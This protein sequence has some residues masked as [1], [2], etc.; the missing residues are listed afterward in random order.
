[1]PAL[2][3]LNE[4]WTLNTNNARPRGLAFGDG[5]YWIP[6][7]KVALIYSY[8]PPF[9]TSATI[10]RAGENLNA[11]GCVFWDDLLFTCD[12]VDRRAYAF[13]TT[14]TRNS[15]REG[16]LYS[17]NTFPNGITHGDG[18][19]WVG[20]ANRGIFKYT[21]SW[22]HVSSFALPGVGIRGLTFGE[23]FLWALTP[24]HVHQITTDG[25][26]VA[27]HDLNPDNNDG[28]A[29]LYHEGKILVVDA[30]DDIVF[31]YKSPIQKTV[32]G[33][34]GLRFV[35]ISPS[36]DKFAVTEYD[37]FVS[38][39]P[40]NGTNEVGI[41]KY[42][43]MWF[44][45]TTGSNITRGIKRYDL[46]FN[47]IGV[48]ELVDLGNPVGMSTFGKYLLVLVGAG[49]SRNELLFLTGVGVLAF[50]V[51]LTSNMDYRALASDD[52]Y[53]YLIE[54]S[55]RKIERY[56][57]TLGTNSATLGTATLW[58]ITDGS[59]RGLSVVGNIIYAANLRQKIRTFNKTDGS[60][61]AIAYTLD[62]QVDTPQGLYAEDIGADPQTLGISTTATVRI[63]KATAKRSATQSLGIKDE[64]TAAR[65]RILTRATVQKLGIK[66]EA[67]AGIIL[68]KPAT[69]NLGIKDEISRAI[70][71]I[72]V[73][74][75]TQ[76]LG[77]KSEVSTPRISVMRSVTQKLGISKEIARA[78]IRVR[79]RA[80]TQKLGIKSTTTATITQKRII[81]VI[82]KLG[83]GTSTDRRFMRLRSA[84]QK[85]GFNSTTSLIFPKSA[86]QN[87]GIKS[88]IATNII[89]G[90]TVSVIQKLGMQSTVDTM[91]IKAA[92]QNVGISKEI[93]RTRI[94]I[95]KR[96]V[97]QNL[98]VKNEAV[99]NLISRIDVI[100]KLGI[101][102]KVDVLDRLV[103]SA[104][105]KL[106]IKGFARERGT[107][108]VSQGLGISPVA[109]K[110]FFHSAEDTLGIKSTATRAKIR[111]LIRSAIQNLG[112]KTTHQ[113]KFFISVRQGLAITKDAATSKIRRLPRSATDT[114]GIKSTVTDHRVAHRSVTQK[115]GIKSVASDTLKAIRHAVQGLIIHGS[116]GPV[117][118]ST[119]PFFRT[120][121]RIR[122]IFRV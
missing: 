67:T 97:S 19:F 99:H 114:I 5:K 37:E 17:L 31:V 38:T 103:R 86:I 64:A 69:Q 77:V 51:A 39:Y 101:E 111:R 90:F 102:S 58:D 56:E 12:Y 95:R 63:I 32:V 57:V 3:R 105:Q 89:R 92:K 91:F 25:T 94:R 87:L 43:D 100:Q 70:K 27:L 36:T 35:T 82:Q 88:G 4:G 98:G 78:R 54:I 109:T 15:G 50:K 107:L 47:Y 108:R 11:S 73:R 53:I 71:R 68:K 49:S 79:T 6:E 83:I 121:N 34:R 52:T 93:A 62:P 45:G 75:A 106:G 61:G 104:T 122:R 40:S 33:R 21:E 2:Q 112:I 76:S 48:S 28:E 84:T 10:P 30:T 66:D 8:E 14:G 55:N 26:V 60:G 119:A 113:K 110:T 44:T 18:F 120:A 115:L 65:T 46:G 85:L 23:G 42:N 13:S 9:T 59:I 74:S 22:G 81:Q 116:A 96:R 117:L 20:D 72:K 16:R 80:V 118:P 7:E 1:M 29:I 24:T 41:T